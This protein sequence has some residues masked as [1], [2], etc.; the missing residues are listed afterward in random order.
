MKQNNNCDCNTKTTCSSEANLSGTFTDKNGTIFTAT[1]SATA[2][3]KTACDAQD[4]AQINVEKTLENFIAN[5]SPEIVDYTYYI[6]YKN[7]CGELIYPK[8]CYNKEDKFTV[9]MKAFRLVKGFTATTPDISVDGQS[10]SVQNP[11]YY[12]AD[13]DCTE[14]IGYGLHNH[15]VYINTGGIDI[16]IVNPSYNFN[17]QFFAP[18]KCYIT[19]QR[20]KQRIESSINMN[21]VQGYGGSD[22]DI[23]DYTHT[24]SYASASTIG[25]KFENNGFNLKSLDGILGISN[26]FFVR[27]FTEQGKSFLEYE[28]TA[29]FVHVF[30]IDD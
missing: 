2:Q 29:T 17:N 6:D 8:L 3:G 10:A 19:N 20:T 18:I 4:N 9:E 15:V 26:T 21:L 1:M 5:Y 25:S 30:D 28:T 7:K 16:E 14:K 13:I 12:Y 23:T 27:N 11:T 22:L 24:S